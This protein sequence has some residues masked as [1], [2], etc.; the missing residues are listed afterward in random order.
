MCYFQELCMARR[1][2]GV[3]RA[4]R[5]RRMRPC[6]KKEALVCR[7]TVCP[8]RPALKRLAS[9]CSGLRRDSPARRLLERPSSVR[10]NKKQENCAVTKKSCARLPAM[11]CT[12]ICSSLLLPVS[13]SAGSTGRRDGAPAATARLR[14]SS[15][16][17]ECPRAPSARC[18]PSW[19][20]ESFS[21]G[22]RS[23]HGPNS[24]SGMA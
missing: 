9:R 5:V 7:A 4:A 11:L 22:R 13:V 16:G 8:G 21:K 14:R 17:P 15:V 2:T 1:I 24:H 10:R 18:W 19:N 6:V 3:P 12:M 23:W 20:S